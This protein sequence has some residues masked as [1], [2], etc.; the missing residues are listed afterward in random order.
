[1]F[2]G[3]LSTAQERKARQSSS[4]S[5][6][7]RNWLLDSSY[8][9]HFH[10]LTDPP[11]CSIQFISFL[12]G[13]YRRVGCFIIWPESRWDQWCIVEAKE[14]RRITHF[15]FKRTFSEKAWS[16]WYTNNNYHP[17]PAEINTLFICGILSSYLITHAFII[18]FRM[19]WQHVQLHWLHHL[20]LLRVPRQPNNHHL[21][22]EMWSCVSFQNV[23]WWWKCVTM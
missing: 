6:Q 15:V 1:M 20:P 4:S 17:P 23:P 9:V 5:S 14:K 22:H 3:N 21:S 18:P 8:S 7:V 13:T 2:L 19:R 16:G 11:S 12:L 10:M